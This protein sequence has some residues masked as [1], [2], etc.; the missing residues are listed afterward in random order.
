MPPFE[1]DRAWVGLRDVAHGC[2]VLLCDVFGTIHDGRKI[3]PAAAEALNRFRVA[4][5]TVVLVSNAA[6]PGDVLAQ[7]LSALGLPA[8]CHDAV[9]TSAD[10]ARTIVVDR[11]AHR[12][13][14]IGQ[15]R[16]RIALAGLEVQF[17]TILDAELILCTGYPDAEIKDEDLADAVAKGLDLI[18]TNPDTEIAI[19]T[20]TLRFAGLA[21]N[22]YCA[23]GGRVLTTGKPDPSIYMVALARAAAIRGEAAKPSRVIAIGDSLRLDIIGALAIGIGALWI[24][25]AEPVALE[26]MPEAARARR[27]PS[28][29]W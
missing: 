13:H 28:L 22:R 6:A 7:S 5:G 20:K 15:D 26:K 27:L 4:G 18:C 24:S 17:G 29:I 3:F 9:V 2:D 11:S 23:I 21:A 14:H 10:L 16:D 19:E 12:I 1:I 25:N 8:G